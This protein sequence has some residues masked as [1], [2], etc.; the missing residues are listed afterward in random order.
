[1][2]CLSNR[3]ENTRGGGGGGGVTTLIKTSIITKSSFYVSISF[4]ITA[5]PLRE[6]KQKSLPR[7]DGCGLSN[8]D[9]MLIHS[10]PLIKSFGLF[11]HSLFRQ[12]KLE[13]F[14]IILLKFIHQYCVYVPDRQQQ[15]NPQTSH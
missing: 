7:A 5:I 14:R 8:F 4:N 10:L 3:G 1:M 9:G 15:L 11:N 12:G 2:E 6:K 13:S